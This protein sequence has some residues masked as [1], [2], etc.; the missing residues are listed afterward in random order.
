MSAKISDLTSATTPLAGTELIEIVQG[1]ASKKVAVSYLTTGA[2]IREM[3]TADRTYYVRTDGSNSNNGLTNTSGGAFLTIQKAVD[4][5]SS[6]LDC[7]GKN[8]TIQLGD[9]TY[10]A[11]V[12]MRPIV[13]ASGITIQGNSS[14]PANVVVSTTSASAFVN[15]V[16]GLAVTLKDL[17]ITTVTAGIAVAATNAGAWNISG[18]NFG[19]CA[20]SHMYAVNGGRIGIIGNYAISGGAPSHY[21]FGSLGYISGGSKTV[22]ITGTPNFTTAF[23]YAN[24]PGLLENF[25]FTFSGSAT[26]KRYDVAANAVC[27]T[28]GGGASYFPGSVAGTTATGGQYI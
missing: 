12:A 3:L 6:S 5:I 13:G 21:Y 15:D 23:A 25:G 9:G 8:I 2:L 14:T 16:A 20:N 24:T 28:G 10:T 4:V 27:F 1:G 19:S 22:T 18:I 26:G 17:K 7:A 11:G